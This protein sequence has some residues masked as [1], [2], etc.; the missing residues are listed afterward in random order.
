MLLPAIVANRTVT[1]KGG[2][3]FIR[4]VTHLD[5]ISIADEGSIER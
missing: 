5:E 4:Y 3:L 2:A 1:L